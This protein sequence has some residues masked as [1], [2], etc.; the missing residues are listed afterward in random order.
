M[1]TFGIGIGWWEQTN[2]MSYAEKLYKQRTIGTLCYRTDR[3]KPVINDRLLKSGA[4]LF[5][6]HCGPATKH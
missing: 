1:Q 6:G 5:S 4:T 3:Q 2:G